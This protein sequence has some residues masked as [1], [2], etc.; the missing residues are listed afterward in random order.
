[1]IRSFALAS[2]MIASMLQADIALAQ[3]PPLCPSG[4]WPV[5]KQ[6]SGSPNSQWACS[7]SLPSDTAPTNTNSTSNSGRH[8]GH[9]GGGMGSG[10]ASSQ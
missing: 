10:G 3:A 5:R 6:E 7:K 8:G 1:M 4:S 2:A 9:G